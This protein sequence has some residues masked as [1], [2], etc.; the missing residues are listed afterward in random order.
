MSTVYV[1]VRFLKDAPKIVGSDMKVH[2]PFYK[3]R[4]YAL[5]K[6]NA[7]SFLKQGMAVATR[8]EAKKPTLKEMF[9]GEVLDGYVEAVRVKPLFPEKPVKVGAKT[10][11]ICQDCGWYKSH[12]YEDARKHH[13]VT[14]HRVGWQVGGTKWIQYFPEPPK[15]LE[16]EKPIEEVKRKLMGRIKTLREEVAEE[17]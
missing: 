17:K 1:E 16:E 10:G 11:W 8:K 13:I 12:G 9:K 15:S 2:G 6:A 14:G 7:R 5:P 4:V 3:G